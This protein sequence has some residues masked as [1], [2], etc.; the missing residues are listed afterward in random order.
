MPEL[1]CSIR[2]FKS[3]V[4]VGSGGALRGEPRTE[5]LTPSLLALAQGPPADECSLAPARVQNK[6]R[7]ARGG[8]GAVL[9]SSLPRAY[10]LR[11]PDRFGSKTFDFQGFRAKPRCSIRPFKSGVRVDSGGSLRREPCARG[12]PQARPPCLFIS[13]IGL[14]LTELCQNGRGCRNPS[15]WKSDPPGMHAWRKTL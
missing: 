9:K 4:R 10:A 6:K 2:P 7:P 1:R 12:A 13:F 11:P 8:R 3:G 15:L 5:T 14:L